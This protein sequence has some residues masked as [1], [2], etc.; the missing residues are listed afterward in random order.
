[1]SLELFK[2]QSLKEQITCLVM[3]RIL[4]ICWNIIIAILKVVFHHSQYSLAGQGY[5]RINILTHKRKYMFKFIPHDWRY[6]GEKVQE[7]LGEL[8]RLKRVLTNNRTA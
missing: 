7:H 3:G 5:Y 2:I 6:W 8:Q 4:A 1:M